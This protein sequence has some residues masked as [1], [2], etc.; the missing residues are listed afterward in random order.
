MDM[1]LNQT[2]VAAR[3]LIADPT[4]WTTGTCARDEDGIPESHTAKE[5]VCWCAMGAIFKAIR[6]TDP[7][8]TRGPLENACFTALDDAVLELWP[9]DPS[10]IVGVNDKR[11]HTAVLQAF[12]RAIENCPR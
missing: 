10:N 1:P 9:E 3:A 8:G 12:D 11:G 7:D 6:E 5:A 2:L 4:H